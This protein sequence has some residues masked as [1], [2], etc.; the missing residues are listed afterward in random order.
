MLKILS[1]KSIRKSWSV[2]SGFCKG[3]RL[4]KSLNFSLPN[5]KIWDLVKKI[6]KWIQ[7]YLGKRH[8]RTK[9]NNNI[10]TTKELLC[11][12]P[13]GSILGPTLFLCYINDLAITIKDA[14]VNI[15]L[16]ADDPVIYCSNHDQFFIKTRSEHILEEI[17]RWC[18]LK[19]INMNVDKTKYCLYSS[20]KMVDTFE[21]HI[22]GSPDCQISQCHQYNYL[23]VILDE[24]L[25]MQA[26]F[27]QVFKKNSYKNFQFAKICKYVNI[28]TYS[29]PHIQTNCITAGW[30][31]K[32]Y[33][34]S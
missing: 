10:S 23:G 27:N 25:N 17:K 14:G 26:N 24:C 29:Y 9:L 2:L 4:N 20:R 30:I 28:Y 6:I 32:F 13:Q 15:G 11:G 12:V 7:N 22:L 16:F 8:I 5:W 34:V 19:C 3:I 18:N 1:K 31:R 21:G 33:D